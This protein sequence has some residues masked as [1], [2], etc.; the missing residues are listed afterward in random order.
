[1]PPGP[2]LGSKRQ[3]EKQKEEEGERQNGND[4]PAGKYG[5]LSCV[6]VCWGG[7]GLY[8]YWSK[9]HHVFSAIHLKTNC[10]AQASTVKLHLGVEW[11]LSWS[12]KKKKKSP[13]KRTTDSPCVAPCYKSGEKALKKN[14]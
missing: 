10:A 11:I 1:M 4:G 2:M 8:I 12:S 7:G 9:G 14:N 3:S 13:K 5:S 6:C